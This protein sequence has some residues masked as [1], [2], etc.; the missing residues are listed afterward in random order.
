MPQAAPTRQAVSTSMPGHNRL[1]HI[2]I[3]D[4]D[5][6]IR[7]AMG[8]LLAMSGYWVSEAANG[9]EALELLDQYGSDAL[10]TDLRMPLVSGLSLCHRLRAR[11]DTAHLP[12]IV[13]SYIDDPAQV[14]ALSDLGGI[15][16]VDKVQ[17]FDPVVR[18][19]D[20][21]LLGRSSRPQV[22]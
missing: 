6:T 12:V 18:I 21:R 15:D 4:D 14:N 20:R 16:I 11:P 22:A 17:G 2:L 7:A 13:F 3:V 1:G 10:V 9:A 8:M 5:P 19:L